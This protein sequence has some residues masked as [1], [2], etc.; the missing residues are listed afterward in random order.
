[1]PGHVLRFIQVVIHV[2][3]GVLT[4]AVV[5]PCL[6][7]A[8]RDIRVRRWSA[9]LMRILRIEVRVTGDWPGTE[10]HPLVLTS[11]HVS[12]VDIFVLH[13][14]RPV[15]FVSKAEVRR[16]PV[17]GW[18]AEKT[19]TLFLE[20][21]S[22]QQTAAIGEMMKSVLRAGESIGLFPES[23]TSTGESLLPFHSS[24]LQ[25]AVGCGVPVLPVF[26]AYRLMDGSPN[27]YV[28][29][30]GEMTFAESFARILKSPPSRVNIRVGPLVSS[31][32]L[33]R[34][35]LTSQLER[36]TWQLLQSPSL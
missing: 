20:R 1:M 12:W 11:N 19:G 13:S 21:G 25:A 28:P 34:R 3:Q 26:L 16:W 24:M 23:T 8:Q 6:S 9:R 29:Y 4:T 2:V 36:I 15:R 27:P 31:Q 32:G 5:L 22:R 17:F 30:V 14:V 18:L 33:H 35:D 10:S 7:P